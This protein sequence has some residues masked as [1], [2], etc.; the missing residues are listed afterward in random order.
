VWTKPARSTKQKKIEHIPLSPAALKLLESMRTTGAT[1]PLFPGLKGRGKGGKLTGGDKRVSLRRPWVQVCRA[2]GLV[3]V[4]TGKGK[5][6]A[7]ARYKP[8]LRIHD[9]RHNFASHLASKG[10]SLQ[11]VGKLLGHSQIATTMRYSHLQD[12]ALRD[13]TGIFGAIYTD[14]ATQ[15]TGT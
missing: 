3:E 13:A 5:R 15:K 8:T 4:V 6:R 9:L 2:A 7:I 14:A 10:V 11:I 1:G 12:A